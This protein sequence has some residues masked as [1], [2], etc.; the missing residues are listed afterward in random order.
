[1]N[2]NYVQVINYKNAYDDISLRK[3]AVLMSDVVLPL[4]Q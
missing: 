1:M 4:S 2:W 3:T